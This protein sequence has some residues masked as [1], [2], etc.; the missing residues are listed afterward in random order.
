MSHTS[1]E[2]TVLRSDVPPRKV[3][4]IPNAVDGRRFAPLPAC[5]PPG[6]VVVICMNRLEYRKGA[7]PRRAQRLPRGRMPSTARCSALNPEP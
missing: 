3:S 6:R 7:P 1:K 5:R 2:N 4:V